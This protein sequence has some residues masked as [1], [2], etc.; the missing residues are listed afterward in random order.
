[1]ANETGDF[2]SG[3]GGGD[4]ITS[5]FVWR[6]DCSNVS[7]F[8]RSLGKIPRN[9]YI[10]IKT[11]VENSGLSNPVTEVTRIVFT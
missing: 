3:S 10:N 5:S 1:M 2:P 4:V 6:S 7:L 8:K 9:L 11:I